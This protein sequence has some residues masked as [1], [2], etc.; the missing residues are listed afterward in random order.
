MNGPTPC[1]PGERRGRDVALFVAAV[2]VTLG[3][4]AMLLLA[5]RVPYADPWR[6]LAHYLTSSFPTNVVAADNGHREVLPN[7]VRVLDLH[8]FA[9]GQWLQI[10]VGMVLALAV[11]AVALRTL[12]ALPPE[13]RA[14]GAAAVA[15][16]LFWLGNGRKLAHGSESVSLFLVLLF[17]LAGLRLLTGPG[18]EVS[19]R[20]LWL[21]AGC[22]VL[23][24]FSFGSGLASFPAFLV[25]AWLQ[26]AQPRQL[27][28]IALTAALATLLLLA[29]GT[30]REPFQLALGERFDLL[31]RWLG[32]PS[33]WAFSP[34]LDVGHAERLPTAILRAT[35]GPIAGLAE[36]A[37]GPRLTARWPAAAFGG[38]GFAWLLFATLRAHRRPGGPVE[39]FALGLAWFGACV[40]V[41]VVGLRVGYFRD[42]PDQVTTQRYV[43]WSMLLWTGLVLSHVA[44]PG[45]LRRQLWPV[46]VFVAALA[47]STVWTA[48][49][50]WKLRATA[51]LTALGG[52]VGVVGR[53]FDLSETDEKD[54]VRALPLLREAGA[55]MFAWPET[56]WLGRPL[57][58][59]AGKPVPLAAIAVRSVDNRLGPPGSEVTFTADAAAGRLLLLGPDRVVRGLA[60]RLPFDDVWH[61]WLQGT[62]PPGELA[63]AELP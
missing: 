57:P 20:R 30:E 47:P 58:A 5:P 33:V 27:L 28:A 56:A 31:L 38:G 26:R 3:L 54:L 19:P 6:F 16:G 43:P 36:G 62:L 41:L 24:T 12:R 11:L 8:G 48:R 60:L 9:A 52:A 50:A 49:L 29:G 46:L 34:L 53:D 15:A 39:R 14:P 18:R 37:F 1:L 63:A 25:V 2:Y 44:L 32:A 23:A 42:H 40:G 13:S 10:V 7:A 17:V 35:T 22:G 51:E 4:A 21:A 45:S 61:G 59:A 55:A